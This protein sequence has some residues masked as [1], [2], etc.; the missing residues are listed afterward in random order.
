[1]QLNLKLDVDKISLEVGDQFRKCTHN[2]ETSSTVEV[3]INLEDLE[4]KI[5]IFRTMI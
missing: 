3:E 5:D 4:L 2:L 1:M